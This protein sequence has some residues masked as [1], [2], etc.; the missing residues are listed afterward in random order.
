[1]QL[2]RLTVGNLH[3]RDAEAAQDLEIGPGIA[4]HIRHSSQEEDRDLGAPLD[5]G[6]RDDEAVAA[7]VAATAQHRHVAIQEV[8]VDRLHGGDR[9]PAGVLHEHERRNADLA[10]RAAIR[11][12]HLCGVQYTHQDCFG[13]IPR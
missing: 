5:E 1:M 12:A 10:D 4:A 11:L 9:L 7:V 13:L 8:A 3:D 6:A 2:P